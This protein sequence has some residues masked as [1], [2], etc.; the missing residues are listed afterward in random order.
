[1]AAVNL[2]VHKATITDG[3]G[4]TT[5][6][7]PNLNGIT[8]DDTATNVV[9]V[10]G[11][12]VA[13]IH[14][15]LGANYQMTDIYIF[16]SIVDTAYWTVEV[17]LNDVDYAG[18]AVADG[19][20]VITS[21]V[22][23]AFRYI[24]ITCDATGEAAVSLRENQIWA[25][26]TLMKYKI[27]T[28]GTIGTTTQH[29]QK[30]DNEYYILIGTAEPAVADGY[31]LAFK[32]P[33]AKDS[34]SN[35]LRVFI[36]RDIGNEWKIVDIVTGFTGG[37]LRTDYWILDPPLKF[38][39]GDMMGL[40]IRTVVFASGCGYW[41]R[42]TGDGYYKFQTTD[43]VELDDLL[44]KS[45]FTLVSNKELS[46]ASFSELDIPQLGFAGIA[47]PHRTLTGD[48]GDSTD[49]RVVNQDVAGVN[50]EINFYPFVSSLDG[51]IN[52]SV[53]TIAVHDATNFPQGGVGFSY[54]GRVLIGT[55]EIDYIYIS[56]N[57]LLQC[58]RGVNGTTPAS[59]SDWDIVKDII[60][61]VEVSVDN[62]NFYE[63]GNAS[64]PLSL[65]A[66]MG[67]GAEK[68]FYIRHNMPFNYAVNVIVNSYIHVLWTIE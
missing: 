5:L 32:G 43:D 46:L 47:V 37:I 7:Q 29:T 8:D 38:K 27:G 2:A 66:T 63:P 24:K 28:S 9:E 56:S 17:S 31:V 67:V 21:A 22:D 14:Y 68:T 23:G 15:D 16:A 25:D 61:Y 54:G 36:I 11:E 59:H 58:T 30:A 49:P 39:A 45:D 50:P 3:G 40:R 55:E 12:G 51:D 60:P 64:L 57:D 44:T 6:T 41:E 53:T 42:N 62:T 10:P 65:G 4:A 26:D 52:D 33:Y 13:I 1:M 20:T 34:Y 48:P 19:G 35:T 18:K